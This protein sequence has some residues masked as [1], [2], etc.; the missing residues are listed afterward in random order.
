MTMHRTSRGFTLI[1][2]MIV[3]AII[4]IIAAVA[5]PGYVQHVLKTRR[6]AAAACLSELT[7][8]MERHY[9]TSMTYLPGGIAT[10]PALPCIA[11]SAASYGFSFNAAETTAT[12]F[13]LEAAPTGAQA[14][15]IKCAMLSLNSIGDKGISA[16][17]SG[18]GPAAACW[19]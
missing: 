19:R 15:D 1:E 9:T 11:E 14:A 12:S 4:G 16:T 13:T 17:G 3:V 6:G 2:L 5:Y 8:H 10:L 7:Q 18:T